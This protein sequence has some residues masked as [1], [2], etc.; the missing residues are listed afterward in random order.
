MNPAM[1]TRPK[2]PATPRAIGCEPF[3]M[4]RARCAVAALALGCLTP[5][6]GQP[7]FDPS[8]PPPALLAPPPGAAGKPAAVESPPQLQ[9][10]LIGPSRKYAIIDGQ[11]V[12]VG[13]T[14]RDARVVEV[15]RT[16]VVLHSE[17]GNETLNL[18][19]NVVKRSVKPAAADAGP[20]PAKAK[21]RL[22]TNRIG[23]NAAKEDK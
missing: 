17:R 7:L 2:Y 21:R 13:D 11:L 15:T 10:L 3:W 16:G 6:W 14:F 19:P 20:A 5:A 9:S 12:G 22:R 8:R 23:N 1:M 4:P 18:F